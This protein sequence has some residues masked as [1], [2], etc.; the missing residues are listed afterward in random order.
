MKKDAREVLLSIAKY[1]ELD[2]AELK[3]EHNR[4]DIAT[5]K[6]NRILETSEKIYQIKA[7]AILKYVQSLK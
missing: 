4:Y 5:I 2:K 7:I 6:T 3:K 1:E